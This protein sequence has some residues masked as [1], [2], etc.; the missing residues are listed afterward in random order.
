[1][2]PT[3]PY[4]L[5]HPQLVLQYSPVPRVV[6]RIQPVD[7]KAN[8]RPTLPLGAT[9]EVRYLG[10]PVAATTTRQSVG[11]VA[12]SWSAFFLTHVSRE[13]DQLIEDLPAQLATQRPDPEHVS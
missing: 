6:S 9:G 3:A 10:V 12:F 11:T 1:S 4:V 5:P 8:T 2:E 7:V 13:P